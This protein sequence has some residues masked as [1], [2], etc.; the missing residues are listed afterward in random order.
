MIVLDTNII[1]EVMRPTPNAEVIAW[2]NTQNALNLFISSVTIA[3]IEYGLQVL[4]EGQ[5]R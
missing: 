4:S 2:L 5:K 1:S 3:E